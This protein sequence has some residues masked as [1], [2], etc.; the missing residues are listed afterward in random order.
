MA[1]KR[2]ASYLGDA[3]ASDDRVL[4]EKRD[5]FQEVKQKAAQKIVTTKK[6][7]SV[8]QLWNRNYSQI[9]SRD[10]MQDFR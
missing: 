4:R 8:N 10:V 9:H 7:L 3:H 6:Q 1:I 5:H 2:T